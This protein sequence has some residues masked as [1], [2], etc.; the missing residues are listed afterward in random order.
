MGCHD[1]CDALGEERR[2]R[3]ELEEEVDLLNIVLGG[4]RD[5]N[6][7]LREENKRLEKL[8]EAL[9]HIEWLEKLLADEGICLICG[10]R[11]CDCQEGE[12]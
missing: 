10:S 11:G 3:E 12:Q 7:R 9:A 6:E 4:A 5:E 2:G 8:G 1:Q